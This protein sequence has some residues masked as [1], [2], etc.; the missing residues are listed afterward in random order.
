MTNEKKERWNKI[1][2]EINR[3]RKEF[4]ERKQKIRA[5][6]KMNKDRKGQIK[7]GSDLKENTPFFF[8]HSDAI[9]LYENTTDRLHCRPVKHLIPLRAYRQMYL[10]YLTLKTKKKKY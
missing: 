7:R 1:C 9:Q 3:G 2:G 10:T 4:G 5:I 8:A 6:K